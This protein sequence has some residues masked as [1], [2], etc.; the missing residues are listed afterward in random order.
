LRALPADPATL[1]IEE[2]VV[3]MRMLAEGHAMSSR[4]MRTRNMSTRKKIAIWAIPALAI[5]ATVLTIVL[6]HRRQPIILRGAV[7]RQ[8]SDPKNQLPIADVGITAI[9]D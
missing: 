4:G 8:D 7:L 2:R 3:R 9:M 5:L 6:L 1:H